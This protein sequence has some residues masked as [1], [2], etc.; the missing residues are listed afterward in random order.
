MKIISSFVVKV[1]GLPP[2]APFARVSQED[3]STLPWLPA[4]G[5]VTQ[6]L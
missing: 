3:P 2:T 6:E 4:S 1:K 5:V